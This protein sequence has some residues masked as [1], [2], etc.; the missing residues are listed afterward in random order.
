MSYDDADDM[1]DLERGDYGED[2]AA[3]PTRRHTRSRGS[4]PGAHSNASSPGRRGHLSNP[5]TGRL[6]APLITS[7]PAA[8]PSDKRGLRACLL[9]SIIQKERDFRRFGCPNCDEILQIKGSA[10]R[11][12]ECTSSRYEGIIAMMN[13]ERSWVAKWQ[14][15]DKFVK[16]LYAIKVIGVLP[17]GVID[18]IEEA[19][20]H[21]RRRDGTALD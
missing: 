2:A 11:V 13:P 20:V 9:C 5:R 12:E 19:G 16:G 6:A 8:L 18:E 1:M 14:R 15:V 10:E 21:Y 4:S 3:Y 7:T 17:A